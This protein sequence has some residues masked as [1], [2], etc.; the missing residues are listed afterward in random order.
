V[1]PFRKYAPFASSTI[2]SRLGATVLAVGA[3]CCHPESAPAAASYSVTLQGSSQT[4]ASPLRRSYWTATPGVAPTIINEEAAAA[5]GNVGAYARLDTA[6]PFEIQAG[7]SGTAGARAATDDFVITGPPGA[8]TVDGAMWFRTKI[9][10]DRG[11][12]V[13]GSDLHRARALLHVIAAQ[14]QADGSCWFGNLDQ[15]SDGVLAGHS[16]PLLDVSFS[17]PG[18]FP[19][20]EPFAVSMDFEAVDRTL[21]DSTVSPGFTETDGLEMG[22]ALGDE[23]GQV[24]ELPP[25]YTVN[26]PDWH[27]VAN[28]TGVAGEPG[29]DPT[30]PRL[31]PAV[32]NPSAGDVAFGLSLPRSGDVSMVVTDLQGR[33]MRRLLAGWMSAGPHHEVWDGRRDSGERVP[34]GVY[35]CV[36]RFEHRTLT[37]RLARVR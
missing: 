19:V 26:A 28:V 34:P 18:S 17:L 27:V 33:M 10:L 29:I 22:L 37:R 20:G 15:G 16:P 31:A 12:G 8:R 23:T 24:M 9:R 5:P 36:V 3:I 1:Y 14:L 11:G 21:G 30:G 7:I 25:G 35:F 32:P 13:A 4:S 6:W 2:A